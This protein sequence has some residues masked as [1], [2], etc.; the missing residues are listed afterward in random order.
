MEV[1][2][3]RI[4]TTVGDI[5]AMQMDA[6]VNAANNHFWMGSGVAGAVKRAGGG[7]IET[8]A[9]SKGPVPVGEAIVTGA[10]DLNAR[11]VIHAAVRGQDLV[12]RSDA[13]RKATRSSLAQAAVVGIESL[14][15]PAFGTGV[16]G[17]RAADA[18]AL[19]I[20]EAVAFVHDRK[21]VAL[22][23]IIFVLFSEESKIE[24]EQ[25]L[26]KVQTG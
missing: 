2:G 1:H 19:M 26:S 20:S 22:K 23:R 13:I 7:K 21:P 15:L 3:V 6:V 17:F 5:A 14:A 24:F 10:G 11:F 8:E 12:A 9:M 18:A 25:A 16:G 4:E